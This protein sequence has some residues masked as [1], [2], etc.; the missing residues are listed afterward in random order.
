MLFQSLKT[1]IAI[2]M[3]VLLLIGMMLIDFLLS[4][5]AQKDL[6]HQE[7]SRVAQA[8]ALIEDRIRQKASAGTSVLTADEKRAFNDLVQKTDMALGMIYIGHSGESYFSGN[9]VSQQKILRALALQSAGT[10]RKSVQFHGTTW[11]VFWKRKRYLAM[12]FPLAPQRSGGGA[13]CFSLDLERIYSTLRT[14]QK[15]IFG[16]ILLNL[17]ILTFW[18]VHRVGKLSVN[19]LK[20]LVKRAEE[21]QDDDGLLFL[22]EGQDT[23]F[24]K[25]SF[26]L[27][28]MLRRIS[29][30]KAALKSTVSDLEQA[31][32]D[33]KQAQRE[34]IRAEKLASLGRL[35]SGLAHEIG[36]PTGIILGYLDLLKEN[37]L[38]PDE[39]NEV[40]R[41]LETEVHRIDTT[42]KQLLDFAR[43]ETGKKKMISIH[44]MLREITDSINIRA[45]M[46]GIE[47]T[48]DFS[49]GNDRIH[50]DENQLTQVFINLLIN[51]ADA[52]LTNGNNPSGKITLATTGDAGHLDPDIRI[53]RPCIT[54]LITDN[55]PG[56]LPEH[57]DYIFDPFFTTK[58]PGKGTGLGLSVC[59]TIIEAMGGVIRVVSEN[60]TGASFCIQLPLAEGVTQSASTGKR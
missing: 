31:N 23:E 57:I 22:N 60:G 52:I 35:T 26:A 50:A 45:I 59:H 34:I 8:F 53:R 18:G 13:I 12:G 24:S 25:L 9:A 1:N 10:G 32:D 29:E 21:Y 48:H 47:V 20:R 4:M 42:I 51:A 33:L 41:R 16:F 39:K 27:N 54:I 38:S 43:M 2:S 56:I 46:A 6:I 19:P 7:Q 44:A 14:N 55:G 49:A 3:V 17:T 37:H 36:N 30:D 15:L 28:R 40:M 58:S 5:M 11:G